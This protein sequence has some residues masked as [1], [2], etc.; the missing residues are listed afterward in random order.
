V[1]TKTQNEISI[2]RLGEVSEFTVDAEHG[3]AFGKFVTRLRALP[4]SARK[5]LA[6][7][8]EL[9]Y[10]EHHD[11]R[12]PGV[13]YLPELHETCGLGVDEMYELLKVLEQGEFV[14]V[15]GE[16]PFQD[17]VPREIS[18]GWGV[19]RDLWRFCRST[20]TALR[21]LVVDLKFDCLA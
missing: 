1:T 18:P 5:L 19:M 17:V 7:V 21:E 12:K 6:H 14:R 3:E 10:R 4:E 9:A 13:A 2:V 15:E 16:Y 11:G 20:K 8:A